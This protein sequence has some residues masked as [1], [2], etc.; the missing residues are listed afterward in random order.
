LE[1]NISAAAKQLGECSLTVIFIRKPENSDN[2]ISIQFFTYIRVYS[3]SQ[4][5]IIKQARAKEGSKN[6]HTNKDETR[7]LV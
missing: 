2:Q 7:Q 6:T 3:A 1:T 5:P 4:K